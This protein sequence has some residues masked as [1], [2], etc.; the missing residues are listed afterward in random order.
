MEQLFGSIQS[1]LKNLGPNVK[2]DEAIVFSAWKQCAGELL[3]AW[4]K[5]LEF[6]ENRLVIAV[7]DK[8]WRRHLEELSPQMLV[9]L[10]SELGQ[11]TVKFIEFRVDANP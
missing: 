9:R 6:S 11:G 3:S 5:P 10:N 7:A 2:I 1:V 8:T 4:T